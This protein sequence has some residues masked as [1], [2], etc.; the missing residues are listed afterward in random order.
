MGE[1]FVG[2]LK[3]NYSPLLTAIADSPQHCA[4]AR[5]GRASG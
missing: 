5:L 4:T 2:A 1:R 3:L